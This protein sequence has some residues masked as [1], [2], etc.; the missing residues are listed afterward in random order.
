MGSNKNSSDGL[1]SKG[2]EKEKS[3][4]SG[5]VKEK[6]DVVDSEKGGPDPDSA[7][8]EPT[9]S[10][11]ESDEAKR[12][13]GSDVGK[14]GP[15]ASSASKE[16]TESESESDEAKKLDGSDVGK[17]GPDASSA[18]KEPTE[19][20][21]EHGNKEREEA[22]NLERNDPNARQT[23]DEDALT[24]QKRLF[25]SSFDAP[26]RGSQDKDEEIAELK[27]K[28]QS[29]GEALEDQ[30]QDQKQELNRVNHFHEK[31]VENAK[32]NGIRP[33]VEDLLPV[34]DNLSRILTGL[35]HFPQD[36]QVEV[37][38]EVKAFKKAIEIADKGLKKAFQK[39]GVKSLNPGAGTPFDESTQE[40]FEGGP[41]PSHYPENDVM[42]CTRVGWTLYGSVVRVARVKVSAG[43]GS[44]NQEQDSEPTGNQ[45]EEINRGAENGSSEEEKI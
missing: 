41:I 36:V 32:R 18:S 12:L 11:S 19:S 4:E 22:K 35:D 10:E 9:E 26:T 13:D 14:G 17:G 24:L 6:K 37:L 42:E 45:N 44:Q 20:E 3:G 40:S 23:D 39:C 27:K 21:S 34:A 30:K 33:L 8:K 2:E 31:V 5:S 7:N 15:D 1:Q 28:N 43:P 38:E 29:L 16:P 25:D